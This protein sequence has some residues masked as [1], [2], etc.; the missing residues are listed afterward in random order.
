VVGLAAADARAVLCGWLVRAAGARGDAVVAAQTPRPGA[1]L[2]GP[3]AEA[4]ERC[5]DLPAAPAVRLRAAR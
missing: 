4:P 3:L 1:P 2:G 5:G